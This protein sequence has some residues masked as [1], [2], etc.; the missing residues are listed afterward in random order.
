[1]IDLNA[2][3]VFVKVVEAGSFTGGAKVLGLPKG[4]VSR[5]ISGLEDALGVR[6]LHRTTRKLSLSAE[7]RTYY[8]ECR[9]GLMTIETANQFIDETRSIPTGTLRIS[10][11]V[12]F[13]GGILGD[14]VETYL[15]RYDQIRIELVL[16][17]HY[18]DLIAERIDL[19]FRTGKMEDSSFIARK[20]RPIRHVLCASPIYLEARGSPETLDE[21]KNHDAIVHGTSVED[22]VWRLSGPEGERSVPLKARVAGDGM[23]FIRRAALSGLGVALLPEAFAAP[24]F[25]A[26]RLTPILKDYATAGLGLYAIY[27]SSRHLST[28]VRAFLDLAVE[29]SKLLGNKRY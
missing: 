28:S 27:P 24:E 1:M 3:A 16:D 18:V 2:L 6:L 10:A 12:D 23:S 26:G 11:P 19:A 9:K 29:R 21:L 8:N 25:E 14:W 5:K 13:G 7:G 4:S 15:R 20:L 17:D 22:A